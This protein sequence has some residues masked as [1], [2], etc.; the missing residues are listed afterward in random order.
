[1]NQPEDITESELQFLTLGY[2]RFYDLYEEIMI[3]EFWIKDDWERYSRITQAFSIYSELLNY[4]PLKEVIEIIKT[5]RPPME[6]EI[7]SELFKFIR[8]VLIHFPF[9]S[10]WDDICVNRSLVNWNKAG[11]TIDRFLM[12]YEGHKE[13]EYR[14]HEPKYKRMTYLSVNFPQ[15]YIDNSK[16]FLKD[17]I[18]EREDVKFSFILMKQILNTQVQ[19]IRYK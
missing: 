11:M 6:S 5:K 13:V 9:Y 2:N 7:G 19:E 4:E 12:N 17:I 18:T 10:R 15:R 8:N 14:F 3:D 1:M 16:I